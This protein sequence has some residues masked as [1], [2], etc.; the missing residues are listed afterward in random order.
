LNNSGA[1]GNRPP[2]LMKYNDVIETQVV[3]DVASFN[4]EPGTLDEIKRH[5]NLQFDTSGSYDFTDDD[6]KLQ[7][8]AK[9]AREIIE[10]YIGVSMASKTYKAIL[11]NECGNI[12]IPFGP[13]TAITSIKYVDG[14]TLT[15]GTTYTVRGNQFKWIESPL[16]CYLE[17]NY[18]AGYT[19][20]TIPAGLKRALLEQIAFDYANAGDQQQQYATANVTICESALAKA[21]PYSRK[22]L[23]A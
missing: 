23:V 15:S 2:F 14:V 18:T 1:P 10:Q 16:S 3:T 9:S 12:E 7:E 17:V 8:I 22:S 6:T 4:D 11:R 19:K 5:L 21:A 13:I 20:L